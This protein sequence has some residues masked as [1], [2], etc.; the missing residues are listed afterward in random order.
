MQFYIMISTLNTLTQILI[1]TQSKKITGQ[2]IFF[3]FRALSGL[4]RISQPRLIRIWRAF[5]IGVSLMKAK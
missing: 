5:F 3:S 2:V 1:N 4:R